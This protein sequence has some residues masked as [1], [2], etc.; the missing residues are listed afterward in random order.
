MTWQKTNLLA[1][2]TGTQI[3]TVQ[4]GNRALA[5]W[6]ALV[7]ASGTWG[8]GTLTLAISPDG[9]TTLITLKDK[10]GNA[11][12]LT[13]NGY[14]N[15]EVCGFSNLNASALT[16]W[17]VLAGATSPNLNVIVADNQ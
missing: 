2:T 13:G 14:A 9:G 7:L 10:L 1:T 6:S 15:I 4:H 11:I 8:S 5:Q 12:S 3:G 17:A 16:I